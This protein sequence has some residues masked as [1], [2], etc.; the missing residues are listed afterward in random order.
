MKILKKIKSTFAQK[1]QTNI[2]LAI[3]SVL[4]AI[5]AWFVISMTFYPSVPKTIKNVKLSLDI[6][7][8]SASE[9]GLSIINCNVKEVNVRIKGSR[10]Q[11]GNINSDSL[12]AYLD[13]ENVRT[14]GTKNLNIKVRSENGEVFEL[15]SVYPET[16]TVEFDKIETR[17]FSVDPMVPNIKYADGKTINPNEFSC[18]PDTVS[19]TGP[20]AQLDKI[21]KCYA[22]SQKAMTLDSSYSLPS[23]EIQLYSE[24]GTLIDNPLLKFNTSSFTIYIPVLTQKDVDLTLNVIGPPDFDADWFLDKLKFSVDKIT[25]ATKNSQ[26][27]IPDSLNIGRVELSKV[28]IDNGYTSTFPITSLLES[29]NMMNMSNIDEV[30]VSLDT[31]DLV[32]KE[33]TLDQSRITFSNAPNSSDYDY[34]VVTKSIKINA[35]GPAE[36]IEE[37]TASDFVADASLLNDQI[38]SDQFSH[39]VTISC[40][41]SDKVWAVTQTRILIQRTEHVEPTTSDEEDDEDN[42]PNTLSYE[43]D[44][45]NN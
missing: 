14:T 45:K 4:I 38:L 36:V 5:L 33:F 37:L 2:S 13:A 22:V 42:T 1:A 32:K 18:E 39:D 21:S 43:N 27:E 17:E 41:K 24:D 34:A 15:E 16:A 9:N 28:D 29:S 7:G 30:T 6:S 19:I 31:T 44:K 26:T 23:E 40:L 3:Y 8:T 25:I 35:I 20:S 10:T 12:V 11:V